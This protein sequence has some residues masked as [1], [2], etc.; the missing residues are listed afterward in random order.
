M[1]FIITG[2][3]ES[4]R[5]AVGR[6][7]AEDLGWE[8][9]NAETL[10]PTGLDANRSGDSRAAA[11]PMGLI[12]ALSA[13]IDIWI[14]EWQDIVVSCPWLMEAERKRLCQKSS[15]VKIVCL[16]ASLG[17]GRAQGLDQSAGVE[18]QLQAR[19]HGSEEQRRES[20]TVD[21]SR[22]V[23]EIVAEMTLVLMP[24]RGCVKVPDGCKRD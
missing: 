17:T 5:N 24:A 2:S 1:V 4:G 3:T 6:L 21:T 23:E 19:W 9:A 12:E 20:P 14:Y 16:E 18:S 15:L 11:G 7:L 10:R 13:A 8:F 22:H